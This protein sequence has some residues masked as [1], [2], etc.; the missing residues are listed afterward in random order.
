VLLAVPLVRLFEW[1]ALR[2]FSDGIGARF[3][4]VADG[5]AV[6]C[7]LA[8]V[9]PRLHHSSAYTR[10][11][12]SPLFI[13]VPVIAFAANM[14]HDHPLVYFAAGLTTV[15]VAVALCID[16]CVTFPERR[17][18]RV[19]NAAPLVYVGWLSYSLY[20]W[21]QP[22]LDRSSTAAVAAFP[23]NLIIAVLL[24]MTSYYV[25]ERP[26]LAVRR[27]VERWIERRR[28]ECAPQPRGGWVYRWR[29]RPGLARDLVVSE[30]R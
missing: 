22:F 8:C 19:L 28:A 11:L 9:R 12:R 3:E 23:L 17:V 15:N 4:T 26:A 6:G 30:R 2:A 14:T 7:V 10:F 24:A 1:E 20:L 5:I 16:W 13:A 27:G 25:L 21:Q 29:H 18:G